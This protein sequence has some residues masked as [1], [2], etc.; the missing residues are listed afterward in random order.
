MTADFMC[1]TTLCR[2]AG[3]DE[4]VI[5]YTLSIGVRNLLSKAVENCLIEH[6]LV[7]LQGLADYYVWSQ[8]RYVVLSG[9]L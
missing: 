3:L 7:E 8:K 5:N 6:K 1:L 9:D 2:A 4:H